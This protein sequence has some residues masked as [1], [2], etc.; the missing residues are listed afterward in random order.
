MPSCKRN[1]LLKTFLILR[2]AALEKIYRYLARISS[3]L[4]KTKNLAAAP[5][6]KR[7]Q[8]QNGTKSHNQQTQVQMAQPSIQSQNE[9]SYSQENSTKTQTLAIHQTSTSTQPTAAQQKPTSAQQPVQPSTQPDHLSTTTT[10]EPLL[11]ST[12]HNNLPHSHPPRHPQ[13]SSNQRV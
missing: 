2:K 8:R 7:R 10:Q 9:T 12:N 11:P 4:K 6:I 13:Q 3:S 1:M 5:D